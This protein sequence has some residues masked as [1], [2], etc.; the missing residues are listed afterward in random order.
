MAAL[1]IIQILLPVTAQHGES[2]QCDPTNTD[3]APGIG[4][5]PGDTEVK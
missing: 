4:L 3:W 2:S 5:G 1:I